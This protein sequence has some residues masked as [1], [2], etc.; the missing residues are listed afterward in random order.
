MNIKKTYAKVY[1]ATHQGFF[2]IIIIIIIII[3]VWLSKISTYD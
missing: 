1:F 3:I 2:I